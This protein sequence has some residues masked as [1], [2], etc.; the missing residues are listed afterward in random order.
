MRRQGFGAAGVLIAL[1]CVIFLSAT[2]WL[3]AGAVSRRALEKGHAALSSGDFAEAAA[4]FERA[5]KF[6]FGEDASLLAALGE[7]REGLGDA[8]AAKE[9]YERAIKAD[10]AFAAAHFKLG[11]LYIK[12]KNF[13]AARSETAALEK[14]GTEEA[15]TYAR[16]LKKET[17]LGS[18]KSLLEDIV[19]SVLPELKK[20]AP[21]GDGGE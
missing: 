17:N 14:I 19:G 6:T 13:E 16:E 5:E 15:V 1:L 3:G 12:E 8:Q 10:G 21:E 20:G 18:V 9:C 2:A 4:Q 7:A 11:S